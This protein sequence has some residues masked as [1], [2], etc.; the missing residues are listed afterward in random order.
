MSSRL[1]SSPTE[2][3]EC[4]QQSL[5][6][7]NMVNITIKSFDMQRF[8]MLLW[9]PEPTFAKRYGIPIDTLKKYLRLKNPVIPTL[10]MRIKSMMADWMFLHLLPYSTTPMHVQKILCWPSRTPSQIDELKSRKI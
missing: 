5:A 3:I 10:D 6:I 8:R 9:I 1:I 4:P 7:P 2:L